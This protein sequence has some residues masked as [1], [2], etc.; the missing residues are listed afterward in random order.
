MNFYKRHIGDY[1]KDAAHLTLLEHGVYTRLMDVYYTREAP[2]PEGQAARLIG[3]RSKDEIQAVQN[4]LQEFFT[5]V[6]GHWV[7]A[8]CEREIEDARHQAEKNRTNGK[9]GGR[10]KRTETEEKPSGFSVGSQVESEKNLSHKPL[11]N[12]EPPIPPKGGEQGAEQK[13]EKSKRSAIG[14]PAYLKA[15]K[16]QGVKPIAEDDTVFAYAEQAGI[17]L[18]FLRLHWLE[19]KARYSLP[20]AKRYKDWPAVHRKSVRGNWFKLWYIAGDGNVVLTTVGEQAR[21]VHAEAA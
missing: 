3:A 17:P 16:Q 21:R 10:P 13:A 18:E 5:L 14:L 8:R 1:I 19:F 11:A 7:Q 6:D 4:I 9:K 12:K 20:D 15:C 2:I